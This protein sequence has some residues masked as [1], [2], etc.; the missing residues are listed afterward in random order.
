MK[1]VTLT[2]PGDVFSKSA[3]TTDVSMAVPGAQT[4]AGQRVLTFIAKDPSGQRCNGNLQ[5]A[6]EVADTFRLPIQLLPSSQ[7]KGL[8]APAVFYGNQLIVADGRE[9]NGAASY[10]IV[11]DV[12]DLGGVA[13]QDKSGL[14][15]QDT[16]RRDFDALKATIKSGGK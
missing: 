15:F 4:T 13:G 7:A 5:V 6:A 14:L 8:P 10:Q 3:V 1:G 11:A 12:L 2:L 9:D 16:V